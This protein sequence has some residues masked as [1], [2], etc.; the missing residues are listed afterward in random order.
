MPP[1]QHDGMQNGEAQQEGGPGGHGACGTLH[2]L[3]GCYGLKSG[4]QAGLDALWRLASKHG[5]D[6]Q[7]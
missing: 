1:H 5:A 7:Q 4:L 2:A 6:L 3:T